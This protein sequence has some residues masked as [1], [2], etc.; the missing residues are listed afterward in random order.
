MML[1]DTDTGI[2]RAKYRCY[3]CG[4]PCTAGSNYCRVCYVRVTP[5]PPRLLVLRIF[6]TDQLQ[7]LTHLYKRGEFLKDL[8]ARYGVSSAALRSYF[9]YKRIKAPERSSKDLVP[10]MLQLYNEGW[11]TRKIGQ[12]VGL[13]KTVVNWYLRENGVPVRTPLHRRRVRQAA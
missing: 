3:T 8:A 10:L 4:T 11:S 9:R 5:P 12:R 13:S 6:N 2:S 7:E 1:I